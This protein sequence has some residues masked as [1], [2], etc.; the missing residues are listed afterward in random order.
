MKNMNI[1]I[2]KSDLNKALNIVEKALSN[3][4]VIE[5]LKGI[6]IEVTNENIIF[7]TS[8]SEIAIE[9]SLKLQD[10]DIKVQ[11]PGIIVIPGFYFINIIRKLNSNYIKIEKINNLINIQANKSHVELI[12]LDS[13]SYPN[14]N[15]ELNDAKIL[16][17]NKNTL[18][19]TFNKTKYAISNNPLNQILTGINYNF[20]KDYLKVFTTDSLRMIYYKVEQPT[21]EDI[22][23]T[24]NKHIL[25]DINKIFEYIEEDNINLHLTDNQCLIKSDTIKIKSRLLDG[26]F[27][28]IEKII[29]TTNTFN[30]IINK[31]DILEALQRVVLLTERNES[32]V[33]AKIENTSLSLK[34]S[35]KFLG[36][37]E[38]YCQISH[39][40]GNAFDI[41]FDP[42]FLLD[43]VQ[44]IDEDEIKLEFIDEISGFVIKSPTN[45][46]IINIISPIRMN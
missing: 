37:I 14:I 25:Q 40:Q 26:S 29:P 17:L 42:Y 39:F 13:S 33:V 7:T 21:N 15:F 43:A 19:E 8:K 30:Y 18:I 6:K 27:P 11:T 12:E 24:I 23:F 35:H 20:T 32:I 4:N 3:K 28:N 10:I 41:A 44:I 5:T 34:S 16:E 46:N 22:S 31:Q 45:D 9:Y 2:H 36:A 1:N 38:E